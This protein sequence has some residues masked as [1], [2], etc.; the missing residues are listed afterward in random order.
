MF[1]WHSVKK[2]FCRKFYYKF[3]NC[4]SICPSYIYPFPIKQNPNFYLKIARNPNKFLR[5]K[6]Y[7]F[8][9]SSASQN[10]HILWKHIKTTSKSIISSEFCLLIGASNHWSSPKSNMEVWSS[11]MDSKARVEKWS[12]AKSIASKRL[13]GLS[14]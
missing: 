8:S 13:E 12:L 11:I 6:H 5:A 7:Q 10:S 3:I 14:T 1:T 4:F 9:L 2:F